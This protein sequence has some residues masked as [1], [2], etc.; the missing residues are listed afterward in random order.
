MIS[1]YEVQETNKMIQEDNLDIR[2][3]TMGINLMDCISDDMNKLCDNIY[4]KITSK[5][6][7]LV[8][9][10]EI[11]SKKYGIPIVNKRISVTPIALV[12]GATKANSYVPIAKALDRAAQT[13]GV[14]F[15]GGFSA[16]V[17]KGCSNADNVLIESIPEALAVTQNVCSSVNVGT[18]RTGINMDAVKRMGEI[19]KLTAERTADRGSIGCAKLVV[20][21][22]APEDNPFMA[23]AF[24]GVGERD[25]V[26]NV[27]VSGPGVVK[28]AL[29]TAR[30]ADFE[31]LC[32]TIKRTAF[33]ITRA[34][35]MVA[36]EASSILDIPFGIIDLSLAPTPA[37]GDSI[38]EIFE[39]MG[40]ESAGAPGT[41]AA[42][43]ILNDCVKKVA[44]WL[45]LM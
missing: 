17:H 29:E 24:H 13:V 45:H 2:T 11:I 27:G 26:I 18:T 1:R 36:K 15:I 20:F 42:L 6:E 5:A 39:E 28:K 35:Q 19:I 38:A 34:G 16:L 37:V 33:K 44:L 23:G 10:G 3:I 40:L 8:E 14:N 22:N 9:T 4:E 31:T 32:E 21:C 25:T 7:H 43:A 30:G 12:G 41:T